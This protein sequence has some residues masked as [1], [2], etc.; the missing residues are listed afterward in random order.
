[1]TASLSGLRVVIAQLFPDRLNLYG[2]RGNVAAL[3]QRAAWRGAIVERRDIRTDAS[4]DEFADL[5]V[6]VAGGGP[7]G[8]Q[9]A[10]AHALDRLGDPL[11]EAL[12]GGASLLAICGAYQNLGRY[13]ASSRGD[14]LHGPA[15]LDVETA[16]PA[17]GR[18]MVGGV[19]VTLPADLPIAAA[20]R[21]SAEA[22]DQ[23]GEEQTLVG[24]ENHA[25]RSYAGSTAR[26]LGRVG[27]GQGNNGEDRSEGL[28]AM[29]GEGGLAGLRLASYLHGPL[30]PANPHVADLLLGAA[31]TRRGITDLG[32]LDDRMEWETHATNAGRWLRR[33]A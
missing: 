14:L 31:L 11:A 3:A 19:V 29:P 32:L 6:I 16:A 17:V 5:D 18:R 27:I 8:D 2:D 22:A 12:A 30:L 7:D 10:V 13:Y 4:A 24:F 33:A 1:M 15:L 9:I 26:P 28:L 25:G 21:A 23:A 20:G